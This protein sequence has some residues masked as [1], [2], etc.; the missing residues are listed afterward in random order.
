M[1]DLSLGL[2]GTAKNTGKTT[3]TAAIVG[4]LRLRGIPFYLTSIGY[5]GENL[6]NITGLP[7]PKLR[8]EPGDMIATAEKCILT[9]TA[10]LKRVLS[11]DIATPL[12]KVSVVR[13]ERPGLIETA[14][15]NKS[16]EVKRLRNLL[17]EFGPGIAIFDGALNRI[18][19]MSETDGIVLATGAAK[20]PD[21]PR[22]SWETR[23]ISHITN[24]PVVPAAEILRN[25]G[26]STV[27]LIAPDMSTCAAWP[28]SSLLTETD[29]DLI[30]SREIMENSYLYIPGIISEQAVNALLTHLQ[31]YNKRLFLAF[32]DPTKLLVSGNAR[33]FEALSLAL[34]EAGVF[35]GVLHSVPMLAVTVNPFYS[36][37]RYETQT[38]RPAFVDAVRLQL[39]VQ[40]QVNVPVY[41]I[42]KQ[43]AAKLVDLIITRVGRWE[44][45]AT[46]RF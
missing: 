40:R 29:V 23:L 17:R 19:P 45:P 42:V 11:T 1:I 30:F 20:T 7:K 13:V 3:T 43:G 34:A 39:A 37:Y 35:V 21:I 26:F 5:D 41:N 25:K 32:A 10:A 18:A 36:E 15:P 8:V 2:A 27:A 33:I 6:D 12:G 46:V 44:S 31:C 28:R 22:L 38:Y 9:S 4:E 14:G 16:S 24:L